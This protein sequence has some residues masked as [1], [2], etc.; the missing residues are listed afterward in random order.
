MRKHLVLQMMKTVGRK[1]VGDP[2]PVAE[3]RCPMKLP[4]M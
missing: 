2:A 3:Q 4:V 1:Q